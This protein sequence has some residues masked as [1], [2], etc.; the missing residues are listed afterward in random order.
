MYLSRFLLL[1]LFAIAGPS[2]LSAQQPAIT[3]ELKTWHKI[4]LTWDATNT[5]ETAATNPFADFALDVT[6]TQGASSYTVPG[7]YAA[8]GDAAETSASAGNKWRVHFAPDATGTWTYSV[9][10]KTGT[11]VAVNGGGSSAGFMDGTSGSFTVT[12]T[13]KTG[14][15]HR[16]KG[17]LQYVGEHYLQYA[18]T[19]EWF[20]KAGADA[21]ENTLAYEDFDEVPNEGNNRKSWQPHQQDYNAAEASGYTWQGGKGTELLGVVNYLSSKN[22]NAFS[23][24]TFNILGDDKNVFPHLIKAGES[25]GGGN[26]W[27]NDVHKDRFDVSRTAQWE[28]IFSYADQKGM[29]L[30]FKTQETENDDLMDGG[31]VG[32]ERKLYYRELIARF[33]HHLALNWNVG[34]ENTQTTQARMDMAA[35]F[36]QV[37]P[38]NH[39]RVIHT[40]PGQWDQVHTPLL[41]ANSEYTGLS[42]QT[43]NSNQ[44]QNFP[45]TKEWVQQSANANK[46]WVV[47]VD[48]PGNASIGVDSDPDDRKLTRHRVVW[49]NFMAGGAGTEFYYGYQSGCGDLGC[50]DHRS[51]D[52]KYTD[53][54]LALKFFQIHFQPYLP[55]VVNDDDITTDNQDY[56]LAST[57]SAYAVYR[58]D[59]GTTAITLPSGDWVVRW[60]N[61]RTGD[62]GAETPLTSTSLVAPSTDDWTALITP[63]VCVPTEA[64]NDGDD[65]TV[66]DIY[67][68]DCLCAGTFADAD[69]DGVCD[70][71]DL[72]A[73]FDDALL[74]TACDDGNPC[75]INDVYLPNCS[76][77]GI[78]GETQELELAAIDDAYL[79][80][81]TR[82][83]NTELRIELDNRV[84]YLK[85]EIP[86][87]TGTLTAATLQLAIG[88]DE[89]SGTII[90]SLGS[91]NVWTEGN[92]ATSNAPTEATLLDE[93]INTTYST[94]Q[95]YEWNLDIS[96]LQTGTVTIIMRQTSGNDVSIKS[97]ENA[98]AADRPALVLTID[99]GDGNC[100]SLPLNWERFTATASG[101]NGSLSWTTSDEEDTRQFLI[102]HSFDGRSFTEI[103]GVPAHNQPGLNT[104]EFLHENPGSGQHFY[105]IVQEDLDGSSTT[106]PVREVFFNST[107]PRIFP[108][109]VTNELQL[110]NLVPGAQLRLINGYGSL[111]RQR[112]VTSSNTEITMADL[113]AGIYFLRGGFGDE[114]WIRRII[115][116]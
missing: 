52:Q 21:P 5:S 73:N 2:F 35:Y 31:A 106:S 100:T 62:I 59:G 36:A 76:C 34:E 105:R 86:A 57:G 38:Y 53:A 61:P 47:A 94:G 114:V 51:R 55:D 25:Y 58:P 81:G 15:D 82:V 40:Y 11:D 3:G 70:D 27:S 96:V 110:R 79:Q 77:A 16:G 87:F 1:A 8:D 97:D 14:R 102:T 18:A 30:H 115:K 93:L 24:L 9:S 17:R 68:A 64:C 6:F 60:Y 67:D 103:G 108:N 95:T 56:V 46:K 4:T 63:G 37:D 19:G 28:R 44:E 42:L 41:G 113:P 75:T 69:V 20:V 29:Y 65:C 10:F 54:A 50:Q 78:S 74:G 39:L 99:T 32:R 12:A 112:T 13:D 98:D 109:P 107:E 89:G 26:A 23:F 22:V 80:S 85:F 101:K 92:L 88:S 104:Y 7:Y 84:S 83:N 48:E 43:S 72:C 90:A 45:E 111:V 91:D 33:S 66:N 71:E 116:R 49:G